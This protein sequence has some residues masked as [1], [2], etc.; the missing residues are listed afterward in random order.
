MIIICTLY[1]GLTIAAGGL[2]A[3]E[4]KIS[5][6]WSILMTAGG[7]IIAFA[8]LF[9]SYAGDYGIY[10]LVLGLLLIHTSAISNGIKMYGRIN[11]VH[12]IVRLIISIL[13]VTLFIFA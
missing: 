2:Q 9:N 3:K 12:H 5:T 8:A 4:K 13:C 1:G 6:L 11:P 7:V 10:I